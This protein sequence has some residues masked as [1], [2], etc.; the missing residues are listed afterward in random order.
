MKFSP[1]HP[2][3]QYCLQGI[4]FLEKGDRGAAVKIFTRAWQQSGD[5][6]ERFL[7]AWFLA[8]VQHDVVA[9]LNWYQEAYQQMNQSNDESLK[10][11]LGPVYKQ[12]AQAYLD[13]GQGTE[14]LHFRKL[15]EQFDETPNDE[16]PFYHGTRALLSEGDLLTPGFESNY[17]SALTMNHVYFT[18]LPSGAALAATLAKGEGSPR[19]YEVLPT[20]RFEHDPNVTNKKFPGNLTRSYRSTSPLRVVIEYKQ[21]ETPKQAEL[22]DWRNKTHGNQGKI[23]N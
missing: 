9:K 14:A 22:E 6:F 12:L 10:S 16:G 18:A 20:G 13:T 3:V 8:G 1:F 23:I 2:I 19:V 15:F 7:S 11:A 17:Q 4:S 5:A 21:V